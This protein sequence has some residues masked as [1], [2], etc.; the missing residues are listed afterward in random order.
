ML[1]PDSSL[2]TYAG[3]GDDVKNILLTVG[4]KYKDS[5][6][7]A[8]WNTVY[9]NPNKPIVK[10]TEV[11]SKIIPD[12]RNMTLKDA[13]Y[14]LENRNVKVLVKGRGRVVAQDIMP[15]TKITKNQTIN[16]LLN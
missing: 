8:D 4:L 6:R 7:R 12:V 3:Y 13:L 1:T 2:H 10:A 16:L 15:G 14:V 11:K 5:S 9:T